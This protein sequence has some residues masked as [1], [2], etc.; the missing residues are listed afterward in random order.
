MKTT[1]EK[2][3]PVEYNRVLSLRGL[4]LEDDVMEDMMKIPVHTF[5]KYLGLKK[6]RDDEN[7][8]ALVLRDEKGN[9]I[10]AGVVKYHKPENEDQAGNWSYEFTFNEEDVKE[11]HQYIVTDASF[12]EVLQNI[13]I[14]HSISITD[15]NFAFD[16]VVGFFIALKNVL[17]QNVTPTEEFEIES[18]GYFVA[19]A[20]IE[21]DE[22]VYSLVP[23]GEMKRLIK[24]DSTLEQD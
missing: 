6:N 19:T 15:M 1:I 21:G 4:I 9:F 20:A 11:A 5:S 24:D 16:L 14:E 23:S 12:M 3:L 10:L 2:A 22:K 13:A 17:E 8:T 7:G 18:E